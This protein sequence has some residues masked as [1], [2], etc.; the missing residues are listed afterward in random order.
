MK[1]QLTQ[2]NLQKALAVMARVASSRTEL[3]IL[4]NVLITAKQD[5]IEFAATNLEIAVTHQA[6]AKITNPGKIA[7]PA[8]L[9]YEFV[10]QLPKDD[11]VELSLEKNRLLISAGSYSSHIQGVDPE[12]FPA[13]PQINT[14]QQKKINNQLLINSINKT[15]L[16]ASHDETRPIL[17]GVYIHTFNKELCLTATDGYRL[18]ES[19]LTE[20]DIEADCVVPSQALQESLKICQDSSDEESVLYFAEGQFALSTNNT[21][22]ISRLVDGK[23]PEYRKLIPEKS[24]TSF[25]I[26]KNEFQTAAKLAG[27]FARESGGSITISASEDDGKVTIAS[28]ASQVGDNSS[29]VEAKVKGN[30][31]VV[32]NVR[33]LNDA[34]NCFESG[35]VDFRFGDSI[36]PC[37]VSSKDQ[38]GYQHIV[39]PLKS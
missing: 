20:S 1:I 9:F 2:Q 17:G 24:E 5:G 6:S 7:V 30:G 8:R 25:K 32:L 27:L 13:L 14:K 10:S 16:A 34:L 11:V 38:P 15:L 39:M 3:P 31:E 35:D 23:Y 18:A 37:V 19:K 29:A 12:D 4:S 26:N 22:L 33:Y 36:A 21:Q 28:V